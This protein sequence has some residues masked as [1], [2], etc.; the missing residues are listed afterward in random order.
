MSSYY[1]VHEHSRRMKH[2]R[3]PHMLLGA[4]G[5]DF[6]S[7]GVEFNARMSVLRMV[8]TR[9]PERH[10]STTLKRSC[11]HLFASSFNTAI[12]PAATR[13]DDALVQS[14]VDGSTL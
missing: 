11:G 9:A 2:R 14:V 12:L 1:P 3:R 13:L 6:A 10:A 8:R 5:M 4:A 7:W